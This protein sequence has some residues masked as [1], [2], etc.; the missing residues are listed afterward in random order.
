MSHPEPEESAPIRGSEVGSHLVELVYEQLRKV[1]QLRMQGERQGHTLQATA[2]VHEVYLKLAEGRAVP[3]SARK[4]FYAAAA[5]AMRR[6]L[7]DHARM[8]GTAKRGGARR[9]EVLNV[10]DLAQHDDP[11]FALALD[12]AIGRLE[13]EE[14]RAA[15]VVRLRFY[16]GLSVEETAE[17]LGQSRRTTLRDWEFARAWLRDALGEGC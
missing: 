9:R 3:W 13:R 16:A 12:D 17:T 10:A 1:A 11:S 2:L 6:V 4:E 15:A 5:E 8:R 14:P 7:I